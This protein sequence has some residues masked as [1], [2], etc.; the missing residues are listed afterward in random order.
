ML[1][2][3]RSR[4]VLCLLSD[5]PLGYSAMEMLEGLWQSYAS[6]S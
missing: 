4:V 2:G 3:V 5:W 1:R 6:T